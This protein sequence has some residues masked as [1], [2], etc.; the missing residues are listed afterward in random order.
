MEEIRLNNLMKRFNI[1]LDT[2]VDY[3]NVLAI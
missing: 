1:G 3:L 2:L